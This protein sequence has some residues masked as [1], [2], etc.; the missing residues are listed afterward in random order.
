MF[1]PQCGTQNDG[2]ARFCQNCG[3][4]LSVPSPRAQA[5][6][7]PVSAKGPKK[8][9]VPIIAVVVLGALIAVVSYSF[10]DGRLGRSSVGFLFGAKRRPSQEEVDRCVSETKS[11]LGAIRSTEVAYFAEWGTYVGGQPITPVP[12]RRGNGKMVPWKETEKFNKIGF[13]PESG[14]VMCSYALEGPAS[15]KKVKIVA[16]CDCNEDGNL[17]TWFSTSESGTIGH[18]GDAEDSPASA[19]M[20]DSEGSGPEDHGKGNSL[21]D[22]FSSK[23]SSGPSSSDVKNGVS[24]YLTHGGLPLSWCGSMLGGTLSKIDLVEIAEKGAYN[25]DEKYWPYRIHVKGT[26]LQGQL[27]ARPRPISFDRIGEFRFHKDDYGKY[28]LEM[29][30]EMPASGM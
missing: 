19:G 17:S 27:L 14:T 7:K 21:L 1:C 6:A 18:S 15:G 16:V 30:G 28:Q 11:N 5:V 8:V 9:L 25:A 22:W 24:Y 10:I 12:D 2:D 23:T 3:A 4:A 29:P 20:P 13:A 26:I